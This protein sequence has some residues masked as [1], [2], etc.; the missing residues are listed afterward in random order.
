MRIRKGDKVKVISG[1]NKGK[2][3]KVVDIDHEA[4]KAIIQGVNTVKKHVRPNKRNPQGGVLEVDMPMDV[5]NVQVICDS[6]SQPTRVG[7]RFLSD[8]SKE[9]FCKKCNASMGQISPPKKA[10]AEK[11]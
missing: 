4:G 6:C 10:K 7:A 1:P 3:T 8:G 9:R 11:K 2:T 5:S